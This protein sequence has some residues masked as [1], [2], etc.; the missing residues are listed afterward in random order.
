M[1]VRA[2][3]HSEFIWYDQS[4]IQ[5]IQGVTISKP[6]VLIAF[7]ADKG[8]E[9]ILETDISNFHKYYGDNISFAKHG[10]PLLQAAVIADN[11]GIVFSKRIVAP[12]ATL[13]NA[14]IFATLT[15]GAEEQ[16][17]NAKGELIFLNKTAGVEVTKDEKTSLIDAANEAG[18]TPPEFEAVKI[19]PAVIKYES[20]SY[21]GC[22]TLKDV[23]EL[24][25]KEKTVDKYPLFIITDN[26]RGASSKSF[27]ITPEYYSS[28]TRGYMRYQLNTI[29]NSKIVE[30]IM[31]CLNHT[32][33]ENSVN[34]SLYTACQ[35]D[36]YNLAANVFFD[37]YDLFVAKLAEMSGNSVED[38]MNNDLLSGVDIKKNPLPGIKMDFDS[39]GALNF[40]S[41]FGIEL[42]E[43]SNGSFSDAPFGTPEYDEEVLKFYGGQLD[44]SIYDLDNF[45]FD[46]I[47]DANY[48]LDTKRV[49]EAL[50]M[51]REDCIFME[52]AG[53]KGL[54]TLEDV[55]SSMDNVTCSRFVLQ[56]PIYYDV[57]DPYS[58]KQI[59]VTSNYTMGKLLIP[60]FA[61]NTRYKPMCGELNGFTINEAIPGTE[62][63]VPKIIPSINQK[64]ILADARINHLGKYDGVLCFE[65]VWTTQE[66][67]TQLSYGNNVL[68]IQEVVKAIRSFCPAN[69]FSMLYGNNLQSYKEDITDILNEYKN[70][71]VSIAMAY[72]NDASYEEN[73]IYAAV[74]EF[75]CKN[76]NIAEQFKIYVV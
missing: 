50:V 62:N 21:P 67:H 73:K 8:P 28:K 1:S 14:C 5:Q 59:T 45:K 63:F 34:R 9:D 76:F 51:F 66:E 4:Q 54:T 26:G 49:I 7:S 68:A 65:T 12:D 6:N 18:T 35:Q 52:D 37:E 24:A 41:L 72:S 64:E 48:S 40:T 15:Q 27:S 23:Q 70:N 74:L 43:G 2:Y 46:V 33:S 71:F 25:L 44:D 31:V 13:A 19:T 38:C 53:I 42:K 30:S 58:G 36:S 11:G 22:K 60:H 75:Q 17:T 16:K 29:E 3:P 57:I 39:E 32:V 69:R 56:Y 20:K 61:N 55:K 47:L 10:Q